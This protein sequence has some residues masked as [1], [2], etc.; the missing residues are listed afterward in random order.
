MDGPFFTGGVL[1]VK[2]LNLVQ[3]TRS[4]SLCHGRF[5]MVTKVNSGEFFCAAP[6]G[7]IQDSGIE[8]RFSISTTRASARSIMLRAREVVLCR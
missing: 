8:D 6:T 4:A 5:Y 1:Q 2:N 3:L 7:S